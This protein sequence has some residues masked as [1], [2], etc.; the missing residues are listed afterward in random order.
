MR[1]LLINILLL[2]STQIR[3]Q[4]EFGIG[5]VSIEFDD[6]TVLEFY[7]DTIA[8]EPEKVVEFFDDRTINSWNIKDLEKQKEWLNPE[9]LWLDYFAFTFRCLIETDNWF[10]IIV[11]D[12]SGKTYW[13]RKTETTKFKNWEEYLKDMFGIARLSSVPQKIRAEPTENSQEIKYQGMD[14][15]VVTSMK[16]DWI[17]ITTPDYCDEN[18]TDSKTPLKSGWIK[19]RQGNKLIIEYFTT[20]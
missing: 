11:N 1:L 15:F 20:S 6:K 3:S 4:T 12:E 2:F 18:F 9:V 14:C 5:L 8:K 10:E 13:L 16:G 17:E 19:W 7:S